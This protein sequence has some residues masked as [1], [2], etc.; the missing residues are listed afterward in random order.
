LYRIEPTLSRLVF[1]VPRLVNQYFVAFAGC[2]FQ[3]AARRTG[4]SG[5]H[6]NVSLYMSR[7]SPPDG[8]RLRFHRAFRH[9]CSV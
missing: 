6:T 8:R 5:G 7:L 9:F 2:V 3:V 1:P 4:Y